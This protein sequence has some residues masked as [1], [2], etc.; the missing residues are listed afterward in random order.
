M[1]F[2]FIGDKSFIFI[3]VKQKTSINHVWRNRLT[4]EKGPGD[5]VG[6]SIDASCFV[7]CVKTFFNSP[8]AA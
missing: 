6:I 3:D 5:F 1:N 8:Q 2:I 4:W 7:T